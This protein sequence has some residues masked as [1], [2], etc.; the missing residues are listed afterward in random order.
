ML[1]GAE[2]ARG[3]AVDLSTVGPLRLSVVSVTL[4]LGDF[5]SVL[6]EVVP[7][8]GSPANSPGLSTIYGWPVRC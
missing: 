4:A 2:A 6:V 3:D 7:A 5:A 1:A 8:R